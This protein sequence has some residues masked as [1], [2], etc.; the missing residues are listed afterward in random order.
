MEMKIEDSLLWFVVEKGVVMLLVL[1]LFWLMMA[2]LSGSV[3]ATDRELMYFM[4]AR[5]VL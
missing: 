2:L 5:V 1:H 4:K 3:V